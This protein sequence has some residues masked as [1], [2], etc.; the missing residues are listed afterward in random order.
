MRASQPAPCSADKL[1]DRKVTISEVF[2]IETDVFRWFIGLY[3]YSSG[4]CA[5]LRCTLCNLVPIQSVAS[6][7]L[8]IGT[9]SLLSTRIHQS[10]HLAQ[11]WPPILQPSLTAS[12]PGTHASCCFDYYYYTTAQLQQNKNP[13]GNDTRRLKNIAPRAPALI[14]RSLLWAGVVMNLISSSSGHLFMCYLCNHT[15]TQLTASY[16]VSCLLCG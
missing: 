4:S 9:V 6:E 7:T 3:E 12:F 10:A 1:F 15:S 16:N 8:S 13:A 5:P 11:T 2:T 14:I